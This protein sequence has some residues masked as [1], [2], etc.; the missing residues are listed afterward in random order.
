MYFQ[1][2]EIEETVKITQKQF[3]SKQRIIVLKFMRLA[4]LFIIHL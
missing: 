2:K 3:Y 1:K 4:F